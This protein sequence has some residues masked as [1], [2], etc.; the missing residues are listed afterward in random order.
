MTLT[1]LKNMLAVHSVHEYALSVPDLEEARRFLRKFW[2]GC[3]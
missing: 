2:T 1:A 3:A